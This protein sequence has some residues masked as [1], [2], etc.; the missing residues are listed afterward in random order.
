MDL[1]PEGKV[2]VHITL[3]GSFT[4]GKAAV[5]GEM[6][7]SVSPPA[8]KFSH[9]FTH[10]PFVKTQFVTVLFISSV[11]RRR[12]VITGEPLFSQSETDCDCLLHT[13]W[14]W[15]CV[16]LCDSSALLCVR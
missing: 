12:L 16:F 7:P 4:D 9:F 10:N 2:Y 6:K 3:N 11:G 15:V 5:S 13:V 8:G 14:Q 1:E